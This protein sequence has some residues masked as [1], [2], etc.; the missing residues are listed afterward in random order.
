MQ[1]NTVQ[2][3]GEYAT[4]VW[5]L[6]V[7]F[8][9]SVQ[10]NKYWSEDGPLHLRPIGLLRGDIIGVGKSDKQQL[11]IQAANCIAPHFLAARKISNS[12]TEVQPM[13]NQSNLGP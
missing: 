5:G 7:C 8:I 13:P 12:G 1:C 10:R 11:L 9:D 2:C 3:Q 6:F 4:K